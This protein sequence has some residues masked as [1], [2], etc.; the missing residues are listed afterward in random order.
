[1]F[2]KICAIIFA[3]AVL[4]F[5]LSYKPLGEYALGDGV[6]GYGPVTNGSLAKPATYHK[7]YH[8]N[9]FRY[10]SFR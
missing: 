3:V 2:K 10:S 8:S 1:M 9:S 4:V 7:S 5:A 6:C